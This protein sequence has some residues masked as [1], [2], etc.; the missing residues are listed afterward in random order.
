MRNCFSNSATWRSKK[1]TTAALRTLFSQ[2]HAFVTILRS[3]ASLVSILRRCRAVCIASVVTRSS[4]S[5]QAS[6][7]QPRP[8]LLRSWSGITNSAV[9][10]MAA[11]NA[12]S[13]SS[14]LLS[15]DGFALRCLPTAV[16]TSCQSWG[17]SHKAPT[18][19]WWFS[20]GLQPVVSSKIA[21]ELD[22]C[23]HNVVVRNGK[24]AL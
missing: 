5:F 15:P 16:A 23:G 19:H 3:C 1:R 9:R 4:A 17:V 11:V 18:I 8:G 12:A 10:V 22:S 24:G 13:K 7:P 6:L 2:L 21:E 20:W 14:T